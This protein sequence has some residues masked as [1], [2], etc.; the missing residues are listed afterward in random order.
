LQAT[1]HRAPAKAST[2]AGALRQVLVVDDEESLRHMLVV[3][4]KRAGYE[5]TAVASGE[6]ALAELEQKAYDVVISDLRMPKLGGLELVDEIHKRG[7]QTTVIVMTAFGS[8][9]VAIEAMKRGAYDYISKPFR[10]DEIILVLKKAEERERL[11]RENASLKQALAER[12]KEDKRG[13]AGIIAGG[14]RMQE[15]LRTTRKIAEYKT[16]V[17]VTG[18]SGTGKELVARAIHD[19][20]PRKDGPF[21]AVNC[22]AI[23]ETLIESELFGHRKGS[24]TDAIRDKKGLFEEASGGTLFLDEIGELPLGPQVK[25]LRV[26]Q[27][28]VV[29][30]IGSTVDEKVDVRVVAATVRDLPT[31]VKEGLF[32]EDLYYRLNVIQVHLPPLRERREDIPTLIEHFVGRTNAKLGMNT[33]G[34]SPDAMKVLLD[35]A[36]PGNVRELENTIE[37]AMVLSDG[38]RIEVAGL[39]ERLRESRDRIRQTLQS[40]ELSIKKTTR[41]I[42]E[43]L[44][45]KALRETGGNRTNAAKILE[46]SHRALLYKIK[47]FGID[48]L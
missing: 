46:I 25:L 36:W 29:R 42:E 32:R 3:M 34:V 48:D 13:I 11:F 14:S 4:L 16:T 23:P 47:E 18:E 2:S 37:R 24:F 5:A 31:A 27:E 43:E 6:Q 28:H 38:P 20:S 22:G 33:E 21:V 17:L 7:I 15:I 8:V 1:T 41:I 26:L 9:D 35:Y 44:I 10:P 39:P 30:A 40:G 45:R 19:L 12:R